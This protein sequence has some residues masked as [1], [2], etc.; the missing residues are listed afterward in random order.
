MGLVT[1]FFCIF[2]TL[3]HYFVVDESVAALSQ[4]RFSPLHFRSASASLQLEGTDLRAG[5]HGPAKPL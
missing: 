4:I 2:A 5:F 3:E 1:C